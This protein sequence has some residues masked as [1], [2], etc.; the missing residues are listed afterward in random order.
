[1]LSL[2]TTVETAMC[3]KRGEQGLFR[4]KRP[5]FLADGLVQRSLDARVCGSGRQESLPRPHQQ[6]PPKSTP[7]SSPGSSRRPPYWFGARTSLTPAWERGFGTNDSTSRSSSLKRLS[8]TTSVK[9]WLVSA[10]SK[11]LSQSYDLR[12]GKGTSHKP[13]SISCPTPWAPGHV[14]P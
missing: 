5:L 10:R 1:M 7:S 11:V 13:T 12:A 3:G 6:L 8:Q 2:I 4:C 14:Q 9:S